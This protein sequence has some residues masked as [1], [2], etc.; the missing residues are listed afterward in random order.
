MD[1]LKMEIRIRPSWKN[2]IPHYA[3]ILAL[4]I[5]MIYISVRFAPNEMW[6]NV[7]YSVGMLA[8]LFVMVK[9]LMIRFSERFTV[10]EREVAMEHG[11]LNKS[12][13]EIGIL[14]IRTIQVKQNIWQRI[15]NIGDLLIASAG[16][17]G[18][19]IIAHG[20]DSPYE[21]RD[22]IQALGMKKEVELNAAD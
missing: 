8:I 11:I 21:L 14:Q 1:N 22:R 18:Y 16:T 15:V 12:S 5:V 3:A 19:E 13:I 20:V 6:G 17:E 2:Y 9:V 4:V 7:L 10:R